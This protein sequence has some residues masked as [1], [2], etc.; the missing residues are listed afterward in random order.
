MAVWARCGLQ[1]DSTLSAA[2]GRVSKYCEAATGLLEKQKELHSDNIVHFNNM[3]VRGPTHPCPYRGNHARSVTWALGA[4]RCTAASAAASA[5]P[6][7]PPRCAHS[8]PLRGLLVGKTWR[9]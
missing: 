7:L 1:V 2:E 3:R 4:A 8:Q 6:L 5:P 9:T